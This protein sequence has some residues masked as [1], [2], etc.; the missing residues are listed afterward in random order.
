M[1]AIRTSAAIA[2]AVMLAAPMAHADSISDY[3]RLEAAIGQSRYTAQSDGT[4]YQEGMPHQLKLN[5]PAW[6]AGFTGP[7]YRSASWGVDWHVNYTDLGRVS[8]DCTCTPLDANY[9]LATKRKGDMAIPDAHFQGSG[10]ARGVALTL[11]PYVMYRGWRF[12]IEGGLF[13]YRPEFDVTVSDL[14][15]SMDGPR[16]TI[17][18]STP[19]AVQLGKV[20]GVSVGRGNFRVAYKHYVL[21]TRYD[22]QHA[23]AMWRGA[24]VI[25]VRYVF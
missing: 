4:Y 12:G 3:V 19:R 22:D 23:P 7:V 6:S 16:T 18:A 5:A 25:E 8:V 11:E 1:N 2:A 10:R 9:D 14:A 20:I 24:D 15:Y 21:P 13:P 17:N